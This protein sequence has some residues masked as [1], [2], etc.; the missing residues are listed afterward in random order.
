MYVCVLPYVSHHPNGQ[1]HVR[2]TI[3]VSP[4]DLFV[5]EEVEE[6][7]G[8]RRETYTKSTADSVFLSDTCGA[9][10]LEAGVLLWGRRGRVLTHIHRWCARIHRCGLAAES[11]CRRRKCYLVKNQR[12]ELFGSAFQTSASG[13]SNRALRSTARG[14]AAASAKTTGSSTHFRVPATSKEG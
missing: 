4:A 6:R 2:T 11:C 12:R 5:H 8:E 13:D 3:H 10:A 9:S 14:D 7:N 1:V